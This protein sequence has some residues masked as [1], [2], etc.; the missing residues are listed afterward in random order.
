MVDVA[1]YG[2]REGGEAV[3]RVDE[4]LGEEFVEQVGLVGYHVVDESDAAGVMVFLYGVGDGAEAGGHEGHPVGEYYQ[5]GVLLADDF[6]GFGPVEWVAGVDEPL[7]GEV[8]GCGV[9]GELG[10]PGEEECGVLECE[11]DHGY[12]VAFGG[13]LLGETLVE[14]R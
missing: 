7:D 13:E 11:G 3:H 2:I 5:V 9:V 12:F 6:A 1:Y 10:L 8:F 4:V 14:C